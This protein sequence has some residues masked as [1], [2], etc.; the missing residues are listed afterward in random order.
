MVS[1]IVASTRVGSRPRS[2]IMRRASPGVRR[3]PSRTLSACG[4]GLSQNAFEDLVHVAGEMGRIETGAEALATQE[5]RDLGIRREPRFETGA[6]FPGR[7]RVPLH[8]RIG[9]LPRHARPDEREKN[10]L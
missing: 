4:N 8:G 5:A 2:S 6:P 7:H 1:K 9:V 10:P 3:S